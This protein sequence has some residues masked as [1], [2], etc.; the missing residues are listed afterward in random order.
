MTEAVW[1]AV[2]DP[3]E[4][5]AYQWR[6]VLEP[7]GELPIWFATEAE[8]VEYIKN[9]ILGAELASEYQRVNVGG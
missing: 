6:P 1:T 8:C 9:E 2:R 4:P 3:E 7:G 5:D